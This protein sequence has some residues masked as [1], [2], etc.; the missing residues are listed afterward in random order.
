VDNSQLTTGWWVQVFATFNSATLSYIWSVTSTKTSVIEY[1]FTYTTTLSGYNAARSIPTKLSWLNNKYVANFYETQYKFL[2]A[3]ATQS[4]QYIK[5]RFNSP[6]TSTQSN[7]L[8]YIYL[9]TSNAGQAFTPKTSGSNVIAQF[10][11]SMAP[12]DSDFSVGSYAE[13]TLGNN[14]AYY[15]IC[16]MRYGGL[17]ANND[18]LV[19]LSEYNTATSS[20]NM[21][22]SPGRQ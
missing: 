13:C 18:Y 3:V 12:G 2:Q 20:F 1:Q 4:T 6:V 10:L 5:F 15:Y 11:P 7:D 8:Y 14:G 16:Y 9:A 22:T 21:P 19:Q 17:L